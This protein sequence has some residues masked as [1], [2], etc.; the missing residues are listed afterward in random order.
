[1]SNQGSI[2][3]KEARGLL[4]KFERTPDHKI[5]IGYFEEAMELLGQYADDDS[6]QGRFARNVQK[7][8][9]RKLLVELPSLGAHKLNIDDWFSYYFILTSKV[10]T[11][12][13]AL[14]A[15]Q[16]VLEE[17]LNNFAKLY[18]S[19]AWEI[20]KRHGYVKEP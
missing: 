12:A 20:A 11:T 15:E 14:C 3:I 2:D 8:Y 1:M 6:D 18:A 9:I 5:R 13:R 10:E 17:N 19:D 16:P 4:S 7:A